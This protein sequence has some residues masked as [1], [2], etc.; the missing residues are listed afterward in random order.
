[1]R[2]YPPEDAHGAG[3]YFY[4]VIIMKLSELF[5]LLLGNL[6]PMANYWH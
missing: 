1:M 2:R 4:L 3:Q 6:Q 5:C